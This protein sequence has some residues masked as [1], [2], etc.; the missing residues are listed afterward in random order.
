MDALSKAEEEMRNAASRNDSSA[1]QRAAN[2]L[3]QA[4][5]SMRNMLHQ[6]ATGSLADL[7]N[8][9]HQ[10]ASAQNDMAN[11]VKKLY[12]AEGVNT[13]RSDED[14]TPLMPEMNG[15]GY[16]GYY[17][18]RQQPAPD[19]LGTPQEKALAEKNDK[20]ADEIQQLQ[21]QVRDQAQALAPQQPDTTRKLRKALS[22]AEQEEIAVRMRKSSEWLRQG[23]GS[24]T[25][26]IEDSITAATQRLSRQLDEANQS[27]E[28]AQT[29]ANPGE[30]GSLGQALAEVRSLREQLQAQ[31]QR[32]QSS[33]S[34]SSQSAGSPSQQAN[35][36]GGGR[37]GQQT[38]IDQLSGLR[39]AFGRDDRQLNGY[40]ND[41][42]TNLRQVN[43]QSGLLDVRLN[44]TAVI[45]LERLE[46]ELARR[47]SQKAGAR[48]SAP[49]NVPEGYRDAV[50]T[51]F[52]ALSK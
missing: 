24:R 48:T 37:D 27:N 39:S 4:Q 33:S 28:K 26:P 15:P 35:N 31:S 40:L 49:E 23:F 14:G 38:S 42:L 6:Q 10:L 16:G 18:R 34:S 46:L 25:W 52:K 32:G 17:R 50:A 8:K 20:L 21:K 1:Q 19:Q 13:A 12:G 43:A 11:Q 47:M 29:A 45:S 9:A 44:N 51:Y 41:A 7:A 30:E 22:D 36:T 3:A 2:Q 5:E